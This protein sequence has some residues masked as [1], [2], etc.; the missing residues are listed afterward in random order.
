M[1]PYGVGGTHRHT[2][3]I[4]QNLSACAGAPVRVSFTPT[5]APMP[6][7]HPGHLHRPASRRH[8][9]GQRC[10]AAYERAYADEPF[11]HLL[12]EGQWPTTAGTLGANTVH[13]QVTRRR[14]G[15]P[16]RRR[17]RDRQP[18]QGHGRRSRAVRQPGPGLAR[19]AG[20]AGD[21]GGAVSGTVGVTL[22]QGFRAA[23]VAA[24]LKQQRRAD[25]AVVRQRRPAPRRGR[26]SSPPTGSRPRRCCGPA[27]SSPTGGSTRSCSTP[28]GANA[29]TGVEGLPGHPPH[30]RAGRRAARDLRRRRRGLLHRSHRRTAAAR[31][32]A[33][34]A[35]R[36]GRR[37]VRRRRRGG[38]PGDHDHRHGAPSRRRTPAPASPSPA[39]PRAPACSPPRWPPCSSCSPPTR[40]P[41]RPTSTPRCGRRPG[42]ASTGSTPTAACPPTTR[43]CCWPPAPPGSPPAGPSS[44]RRSRRSASTWPT[45]SSPT[46]RA[47][48]RR[49][50]SRWSGPPTRPTRVEV[51]RAVARSALFKCAVHGEDPNWGRVLSALGT[52]TARFEPEQVAVAINGVWVC[53]DG[54]VGADR[55]LVDMSAAGGHGDR[56]PG[57]R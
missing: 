31:P 16:A 21:G 52:T 49:S 45:S 2:P 55:S 4:E 36:R 48:A 41:S 17:R 12:P 40:S 10:A 57:R 42:T 54:G 1:S 38:R 15:R 6:R 56:R 32:A 22:P 50:P 27:R 39:W 53:R 30:R 44:P 51:G 11:V 35:R 9:P 25:V 19:D 7:G 18:D 37:A 5:L 47:P 29:C 8:R 14:A 23:G 24:G 28:A 13:V 20:P 3:E 26:A 46:P 33:R 43:C 34:R